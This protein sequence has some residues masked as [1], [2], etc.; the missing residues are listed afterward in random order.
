MFVSLRGIN[1]HAIQQVS[2]IL[3]MHAV[4]R[5]IRLLNLHGTGHVGRV[6]MDARDVGTDGLH[7]TRGGK[8]VHVGSRQ[9]LGVGHVL[10][11]DSSNQSLHFHGLSY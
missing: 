7:V 1:E 10:D 5:H 4:R 2:V 11:V 9:H 3:G 6:Q 8:R